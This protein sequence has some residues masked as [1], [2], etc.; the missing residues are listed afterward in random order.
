MSLLQQ[1]TM[2]LQL[3]NNSSAA[4]IEHVQSKRPDSFKKLQRK[5][6]VQMTDT[7]NTLQAV[8]VQKAPILWQKNYMSPN[9]QPPGLSW[10]CRSIGE[11]HLATTY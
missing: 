6:N 10:S 4:P 1:A 9:W 3:E 5:F 2:L 11:I 7:T 8:A